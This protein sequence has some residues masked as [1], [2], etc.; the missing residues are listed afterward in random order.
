MT[1]P[2]SSPHGLRI[3][4]DGAVARLILARPTLHNAFDDALVVALTDALRALDRDE[5]VRVVVLAGDGPSFSAGAD[6]NWMRRMAKAPEDANREDAERLARLM[7]T[8]DGLSK[9][10]V[11][12][13]HGAT[14][15]GGVG[16]VACCDIAIGVPAAVFGLTETRLGLAPATISPFV[17]AAIGARQARRWFQSAEVFDA[18][19]AQRIGLLHEVVEADALDEAV[20]RQCALLLRTGPL[21]VTEAKRLAQRVAA[22]PASPALDADNAALIARLRVSAEGQEGL[23]AFL[24]KRPAAWIG[25]S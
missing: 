20:R 24:E 12:R 1:R 4:R 2:P 17:V 22:D 13:V 6:L 15:G 21:A 14:F 25:A 7:R 8:L 19:T 16:L 9:P 3:E 11:A 23:G 18:A 10:V 5:A